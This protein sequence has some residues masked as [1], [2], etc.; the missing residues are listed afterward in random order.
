MFETYTLQS[1]ELFQ[2]ATAKIPN[3]SPLYSYERTSHV[4]LARIPYLG[5]IL[6]SVLDSTLP[7]WEESVPWSMLLE[8][9]S[10]TVT[11]L[12]AVLLLV[13]LMT[14]FVLSWY[15]ERRLGVTRLRFRDQLKRVF[16]VLFEE[17][18]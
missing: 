3:Y 16:V 2:S 4:R 6:R 11:F 5:R 15:V 9:R 14:R 12:G 1:P 18:G 10:A 13:A 8:R 7:G 17:P